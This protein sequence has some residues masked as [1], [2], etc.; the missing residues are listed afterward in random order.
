MNLITFP[1]LNLVFEIDKVFI[2]IGEKQIQW[3]GFLIA[4][5]ILIA[6]LFCKRDHNKYGIK[7][8]QILRVMVIAL[9]VSILCARIYYVVFNYQYYGNNLINIFNVKSG[10]LAIYGGIIGAVIV[11]YLYCKIKKVNFL[12]LLDYVVP[13]LALGQ[14]IGR[15][16][17]FFNQEAYGI[18]TTNL[19]R[20]GIIEN[21]TYREVHPTFLYE[22]A[23]N[24][25]LF[26]ILY[27][28]RNKRQY[29][30]QL[31]YLYLISY[32]FVRFFIEG[33]RI[34]SLML[35]NIRVS[36]LFSLILFL[37]FGTI[38][39]YHTIK[40]KKERDKSHEE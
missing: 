11:I 13:Y 16:G 10:G 30:G 25:L 1:G 9:P 8:E 23:F 29:K 40:S 34:D 26:L 18:E 12:N 4:I 5:A 28:M 3:Y 20:M 17:N 22:S 6:I 7:F 14:C 33:I 35:G 27:C 38:M 31:A 2:S 36:Q 39:I 37:V 15:W 32:S 24:F 21:G 19:F